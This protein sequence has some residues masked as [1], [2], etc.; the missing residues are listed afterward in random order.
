MAFIGY[1]G[2]G[3][4]SMAKET[5]WWLF[6]FVLIFLIIAACSSAFAIIG[7][8]DTAVESFTRKG[9]ILLIIVYTGYFLIGY[10]FEHSIR[11]SSLFSEKICQL[12][13]RT[14]TNRCYNSLKVSNQI[15]YPVM[16]LLIAIYYLICAFIVKETGYDEKYESIMGSV[17]QTA[18]LAL[19]GIEVGL[20]ILLY[21]FH[22]RW[23][24]YGWSFIIF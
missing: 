16:G 22:L 23:S 12:D 7:A 20:S 5:T 14:H 9:S 1:G 6:L 8:F 15:Y 21:F 24:W 11:K 18:G 17:D 10:M 4:C 2:L 19:I 3:L 13:S